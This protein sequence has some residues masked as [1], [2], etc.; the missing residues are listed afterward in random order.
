VL[1]FAGIIKD[2]INKQTLN[3]RTKKAYCLINLYL[4]SLTVVEKVM[5]VL[6]E[7]SD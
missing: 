7:T 5:Q 1:K 6:T 3:I 2:R 4:S